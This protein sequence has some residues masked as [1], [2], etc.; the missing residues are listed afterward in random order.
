[1]VGEDGEVGIYAEDV[2]GN[3]VR[4]RWRGDWAEARGRRATKSGKG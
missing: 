1:V 2:G 4:G 3:V